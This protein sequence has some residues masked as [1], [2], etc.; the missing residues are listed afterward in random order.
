MLLLTFFRMQEEILSNRLLV[1]INGQVYFQCSYSLYSEALNWAGKQLPGFQH[2][3]SSYCMLLTESTEFRQFSMLI[4]YYMSRELSFPND[5]LRAAQGM[6][7]KFS[8]LSDSHCFQGLP[9]PPDHSLLFI[10]SPH[11]ISR[12]VG[13]CPGFPSYITTIMFKTK[14]RY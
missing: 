5:I 1:F 3:S 12:A 9:P 13:R 4:T 2:N 6:L 11:P 14:K 8:L 10:R 7:R